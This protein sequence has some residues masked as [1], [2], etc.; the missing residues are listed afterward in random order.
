MCQGLPIVVGVEGIDGALVHVLKAL[1]EAGARRDRTWP[2]RSQEL[3]G[4]R[5]SYLSYPL[6]LD[7]AL[8]TSDSP[9]DRVGAAPSSGHA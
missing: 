4:F 6:V 1:Y 3:H 5:S 7:P 2:T 8:A 9:P